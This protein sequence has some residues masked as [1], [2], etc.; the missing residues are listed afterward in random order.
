MYVVGT[1]EGSFEH[2]KHMLKMKG[3]KIITI[4][5]TIKKVPYLDL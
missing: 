5:P 2:P 1:Q 4:L 3:K